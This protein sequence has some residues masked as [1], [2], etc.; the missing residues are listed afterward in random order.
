M[1]GLSPCREGTLAVPIFRSAASPG[2]AGD[3]AG[4]T[5][6]KSGEHVVDFL[7]QHV[8]GERLCEERHA[9]LQHAPRVGPILRVAGDI[10]DPGLGAERGNPAGQ[11]A[12]RCPSASRR[13]SAGGRCAHRNRRRRRPPVGIL[14]G[15]HGIPGRPEQ[16]RQHLP[17]IVIV[18]GQENGRLLRGTLRDRRRRLGR[19]GPAVVGGMCIENVVPS[20]GSLEIQM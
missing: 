7:D 1:K 17:D 6:R 11:V 20:P 18:F 9:A 8:A 5:L 13:R 10:E 12:T 15:E 16:H 3:G 2:G 14:C 4:A 19:S